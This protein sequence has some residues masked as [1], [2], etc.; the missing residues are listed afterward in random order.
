MQINGSRRLNSLLYSWL[1][2]FVEDD[3]LGP[4]RIKFER[5]GQMPGYGLPFAVFIGS[6]PDVRVFG[7]FFQ[8]G[9]NFFLIRAN[10]VLGRE[11]MLQVDVQA[12]FGQVADMPETTLDLITLAEKLL[13]GLGLGRTL[14]NNQV[15]SV[16]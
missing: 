9:D 8:I 7:G 13:N 6:Q 1:S 14:Y 4:G 10:L 3:A 12:L 2:D 16:F 5:L 11:I 15:F